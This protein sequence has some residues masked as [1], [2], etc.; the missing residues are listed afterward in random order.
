M[1]ELVFWHSHREEYQGVRSPAPRNDAQYFD[2]GA[3]FHVPSDYQYSAYFVAHIL[4]FQF[5]RSLCTAAGQYE[6]NNPEKPLHKCD[7]EGS[8]VAGQRLRDGLSLG[9]SK[10]WSEALS[11]ITDGER[12]LSANAI[13]EYFKPL[14]EFLIKENRKSRGGL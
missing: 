13:L 1:F 8:K 11:V 4:E 12:E 7:L 5:L 6:P 14:H 3:K 10:H 9:L 2:A